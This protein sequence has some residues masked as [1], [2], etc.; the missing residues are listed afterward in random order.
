MVK[1]LAHVC[2]GVGD[3]E[4]ALG[5]Y[6]DTLGFEM[7]YD[8]RSDEGTRIGCCMHLGGGTFLEFFQS[9][10]K[11]TDGPAHAHFCLLT[12]DIEATAAEL[13]SRGVEVTATKRGS[14]RS[15][16]IWLADLDG[17]RIEFQQYTAESKQTPF[18]NGE[19]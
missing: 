1:G 5:F 15:Y 11:P 7:A 8:F 18:V 4:R 6:R 9:G 14:D 13:R 12:D 10:V 16:N 19:L 2:V 3:V 17:N